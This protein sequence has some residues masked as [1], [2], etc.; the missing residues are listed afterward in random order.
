MQ[1]VVVRPSLYASYL[2][3]FPLPCCPAFEG[4]TSRSA[5]PVALYLT[6]CPKALIAFLDSRAIALT[7]MIAAR[8][9]LERSISL[10]QQAPLSLVLL[11]LLA[12]AVALAATVNTNPSTRHPFAD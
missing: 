1:P 9:M 12:L 3:P 11:A 10:V 5:R 6:F 2:T 4:D 7:T 8:D